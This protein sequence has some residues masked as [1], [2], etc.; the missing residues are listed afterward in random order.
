MT[1]VAI[2]DRDHHYFHNFLRMSPFIFDK[3]TGMLAAC[4]NRNFIS[5][6]QIGN[7]YPQ[8]VTHPSIA[9]AF[10]I[11]IS[12]A[13]FL[14]LVD[15]GANLMAEHLSHLGRELEK[16]TLDLSGHFILPRSR[17]QTNHVLIGDEAFQLRPDFTR[18]F[19]GQG[20]DA[21][22]RV[23]NYRLSRARRSTMAME[24][25]WCDKTNK[26]NSRDIVKIQ[27]PDFGV[28]T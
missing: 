19:P 12:T 9:Y 8:L 13:H 28:T 10:R 14:M 21:K 15:M 4:L 24:I 2:R 22:R 5:C 18:P 27:K 26:Q 6:S 11:G 16:N 7:N 20:L 17:I 25:T 1:M 23:F 3:L